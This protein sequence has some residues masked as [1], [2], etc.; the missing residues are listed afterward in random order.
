MMTEHEIAHI[1]A[2]LASSKNPKSFRTSMMTRGFPCQT[3]SKVTTN[4]GAS[5]MDS[6]LGN[7]KK[8]Q[9]ISNDNLNVIKFPALIKLKCSGVTQN[10]F[11]LIIHCKQKNS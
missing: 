4:D 6:F 1:F 11:C 8:K 10:H 3:Y 2:I 7:N 5:L 9:Q